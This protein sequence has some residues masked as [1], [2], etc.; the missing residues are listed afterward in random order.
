MVKKLA[1]NVKQMF[2]KDNY[3]IVK[4]ISNYLNDKELLNFLSTCK[5]YKNFDDIYFEKKIIS[6]NYNRT[7]VL[8]M[9]FDYAIFIETYL[10]CQILY[11]NL[12]NPLN[13]FPPK[14]KSLDINSD[15]FIILEKLP[16]TLVELY[17]NNEFN[18]SIDNLPKNLK[19]LTLRDKFN[20]KIN[21]LPNLLHELN[22]GLK[23]N[24]YLDNLPLTLKI[25]NMENC[26]YFNFSIDCLSNLINLETLSLGYGF[27]QEINILPTNL[28]EL[29]IY[30]LRNKINYLPA[31]LHNL[32]INS[33]SNK[34]FFS[35]L[36]FHQNLKKLIIPYI[37]LNFLPKSLISLT[38]INN[39]NKIDLDLTKFIKL[40]YLCLNFF[41]N[42]LKLPDN[43]QDLYISTRINKNEKLKYSLNNLPEK[44]INLHILDYNKTIDKLPNSLKYLNI[45]GKFD[46]MI[47]LPPNI[48]I[49]KFGYKFY[50]PIDLPDS[51]EELY[52]SPKY[53]RPLIHP[54]ILKILKYY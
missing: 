26:E 31:N 52:L 1:L 25:L 27:C 13:L 34:T 20:Q 5:L 6:I 21:N 48:K 50:Q 32:K 39:D 14:L 2:R 23:F 42:K 51:L 43:L 40:N 9:K 11:I 19:K 33:F 49:A 47:I 44:L 24:Q 10:K 54:K 8:D 4:I 53:D 37:D 15:N 35:L 18:N 3:D 22:L 46:N 41:N 36:T 29:N 30:S 17:L 38:F 45:K 12:E 28:K 16:K 7:N